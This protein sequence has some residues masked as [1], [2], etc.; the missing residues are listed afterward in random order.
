[1]EWNK[2]NPRFVEV[3]NVDAW[4]IVVDKETGINYLWHM[5]SIGAG[6]TPLLDKDGKP[7]ITSDHIE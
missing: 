6:L 3:Y 1:M 7:I 2:K 5:S 4:K